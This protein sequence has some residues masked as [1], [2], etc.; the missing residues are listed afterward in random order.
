MEKSKYK[1][2]F[3]QAF[4]YCYGETK[5]CA[6]ETYKTATIEYITAVIESAKQ[7]THKAFYND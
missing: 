7:D 1:N 3:L 6:L 5:K 2:Q 4:C